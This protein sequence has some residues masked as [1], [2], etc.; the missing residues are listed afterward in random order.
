MGGKEPDS[1][2]SNG[3]LGIQKD[4]EG[5]GQGLMFQECAHDNVGE[6]V[7]GFRMPQQQVKRDELCR[8]CSLTRPPMCYV[9]EG[10]DGERGKCKPGGC[11]TM[12]GKHYHLGLV[13]HG[14]DSG[15]KAAAD[16]HE[17]QDCCLWIVGVGHDLVMASVAS[18]HRGQALGDA[19]LH[20]GL[21]EG[22]L[23]RASLARDQMGRGFVLME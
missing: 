23:N 3:L 19:R 16:Q 12:E 10:G 7:L 17:G 22:P 6:G 14:L 2:Q 8:G 11:W 18:Y 15:G 21:G 9:L 4:E 1:N 5:V 20:L 13:Y